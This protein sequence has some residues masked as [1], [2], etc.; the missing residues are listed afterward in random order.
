MKQTTTITDL[1]EKI[2]LLNSKVENMTKSIRM[3]NNGS[4]MLDE[5]L[6]I[7]KMLRNLKGIGFD[8]RSMSKKDTHHPKKF[9][10]PKDKT[11]FQMLDHISQYPA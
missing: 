11:E 1:E 9:V 4:D 3:L 7:G 5:I 10:Y 8:P 2:A 6:E